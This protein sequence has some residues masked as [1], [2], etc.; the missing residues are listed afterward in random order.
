MDDIL[1]ISGIKRKSTAAES[2]QRY[3]QTV[4]LILSHLKRDADKKKIFEIIGPKNKLNELLIA[5]AAIHAYHNLGIRLKD[6]V[7]MGNISVESTFQIE[8]MEKDTL[9]KEIDSFVKDSFTR[10]IGLHIRLLKLR[11]RILIHLVNLKNLTEKQIEQE[12]SLI[13]QDMEEIIVELIQKYPSYH[14]Y[15]FIGD[16]LGLSHKIKN[17]ILEEGSKLKI[18]SIDLEKELAMKERPDKY[19][20]L[21]AF[22]RI[23][24][25]L[26][27]Q[28]EFRS[29][30]DLQMQTM[31]IRMILRKALEHNYD[32]F[33]ISMRG[34][35]YYLNA[36]QTKLQIINTIENGLEQ[37]KNYEVFEEEI[38]KFIKEDLGEK[39]KKNVN[40]FVYYL[41][42]LINYSFS[43]TI[44][45]LKKYGV[46]NLNHLNN[47]TAE[48]IEK[49]QETM[50]NFNITKFDIIKLRDPQKNPIV[51]AKNCFNKLKKG[52]VKNPIIPRNQDEPSF[53]DLKQA[54]SQEEFK[55]DI[56]KVCKETGVTLK[57]LKTY[58]LKAQLI[59]KRIIQPNNL[60]DYSQ[61]LL[62]LNFHDIFENLSKEIYFSIFSEILRHLGRILETYIK[63]SDDKALFLLGLRKIFTTTSTEGWVEVKIEELMIER[64]IKRQKE[65]ST[66]FN[67]LN[68]T[69]LVNGF[70]LSRL[71]D[72]GLS[73]GI[74]ELKTEVSPIFE[75]IAPL[76]LLTENLSPV[77]Y[78][79][80]YDLIER[81][82]TFEELRKLKVEA[83]SEEKKQKEVEKKKD[84]RKKQEISTLN[85]IERKITS[86]LMRITSPGINPNQLYWSEKDN[87][88]A[89]ENLKMH[90]ELKG[91][92]IE[93]MTQFFHF[94]LQKMKELW[95]QM[96]IPVYDK[97]KEM[98]I[99]IAIPIVQKRINREPS[100][101]D[102]DSMIEGERFEIAKQISKRIG[103]F[104]DKALYEK[105]KNNRK[106]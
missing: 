13:K 68:D 45:L 31:S 65:L 92:A 53:I 75:D 25:I 20:E 28:F 29:F 67:A 91:H 81:F 43:D 59:D 52:T 99:K 78:V 93:L 37:E 85:W 51:L 46:Y 34:I 102:Y 56:E 35:H 84:L 1:S 11:Q 24:K 54:M 15:D 4:N 21:S 18:I 101:D 7:E 96:K 17:E 48:M 27:D 106:K 19:I 14:F 86:S 10:E 79:I 36:N 69:F 38:L 41:Q 8:K 74:K 88:T 49:I 47:V 16:L 103:K 80:A 5:A 87:K 73:D 105:F 72:R 66:I 58:F 71:T 3:F 76:T 30:K 95:E 104:L 2:T 44:F 60:Q 90:S 22:A 82:R 39:I 89:T 12:E 77:S 26:K 42:N 64:L 70:I 9:Y 57:E 63:L 32:N 83:T 6:P 94:A 33:P 50:K 100:L 40:E 98:V 23:S 61:L 97:A 62:I 55:G